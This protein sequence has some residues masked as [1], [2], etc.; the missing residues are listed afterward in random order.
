MRIDSMVPH[1]VHEKLEPNNLN[2]IESDPPR[3]KCFRYR[4]AVRPNGQLGNKYLGSSPVTT[5]AKC[6]NLGILT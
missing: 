5:S 6:S 3:V 2:Q 1:N 4:V